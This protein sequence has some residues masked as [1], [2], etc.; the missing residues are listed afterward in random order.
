M[1]YV[2]LMSAA[3]AAVWFWQKNLIEEPPAAPE[4]IPVVSTIL[5]IRSDMNRSITL[6]GYTEASNS[7]TVLPLISGRITEIPVS[8]GDLLKAGTLVARID[9]SRYRL[10][11]D[12]AE[13]AYLAARSNFMR[14]E[15]L[16]GT[17]AVTV[18][19]YDQAKAER[20]ALLYQKELADLQL[21][22][23]EVRTPVDGTV[24]T[25][26]A[27]VGSLAASE[28][29]LVT[30]ADLSRLEVTFHVPE[31]HYDLFASSYRQIPVLISRVGSRDEQIL[32]S[33]TSVSSY[34]DPVPKT[35]ETVCS[36]TDGGRLRPGMQLEIECLLSV[37]EDVLF[38]PFEVQDEANSIWY[39]DRDMRAHQVDIL[40]IAENDEGFAVDDAFEG[41]QIIRDGQ[42]FLKEGQLVRVVPGGER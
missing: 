15:N 22:Y 39:V 27:Q 9:P 11:A 24:L 37:Y 17:G 2:L 33:I 7:V 34:I 38:L 23:T 16:Y 40:P 6:R 32:G 41:F 18:Q 30:I 13:A 20:D 42:H 35:F 29:P 21:A 26:H 4:V 10:Q 8:A 12:S 36:I 1:V 31:I 14:I 25:V 28:I 19:V 3:A 5:P